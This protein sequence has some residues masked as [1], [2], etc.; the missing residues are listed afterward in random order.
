M[1]LLQTDS[2]INTLSVP[3][4]EFATERPESVPV[5]LDIP[6]RLALDKSVQMIAPDMVLASTWT[7]FLMPPS[8][9]TS[10]VVN[11]ELELKD[12]PVS[13]LLGMLAELVLVSVMPPGPELTVL[14]KSA[15]TET[16]TSPPELIPVLPLF[17]KSK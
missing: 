13:P 4:R 6:E 2:F 8:S 9:T 12:Q 14:P 10:L 16:T 3:P 17:T 15:H 11:L 7:N 1:P 5:W